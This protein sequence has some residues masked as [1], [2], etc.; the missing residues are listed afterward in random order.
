PLLAGVINIYKGERTTTCWMSEKLVQSCPRC[1][2]RPQVEVIAEDLNCFMEGIRQ[3]SRTA[4]FLAWGYSGN[5]AS[6]FRP[7]ASRLHPDIIWLG[8]FEHD[9]EKQVH[10]RRV[11][12]HE[13]SLSA[14]G[15]SKSFATVAGSLAEAGRT[16][17]AKLQIGNS[18][19]L[20]SVP[21]LPVPATVC[22]KVTAMRG[23]GVKG[24]MMSWI[25]GGY[26]S[27]QLKVAGE[28]CF[29]PTRTTDET[30]RRVAALSW[31]PDQATRV[32]DAWNRFSNA[33]QL[34]LCT[35]NAFYFGP[36]TRCPGYHLHLEKESQRAQPYNWGLTRERVRQPFE[37]Q[38]SRW[39]P[40]FT[41]AEMIDSFREMGKL[42]DEGLSL[43]KASLNGQPNL[44]ELRRQYAVAAAIRIQLDSMAN[45]IEFYTLRD[46]LREAVAADQ[47]VL[48][49]R[50][51]DVVANDIQLARE[52]LPYVRLDCTIGFESE[53][54]DYSYSP[55]LLEEKI[56]HDSQTLMTLTKWEQNGVEA[57]V[58]A[59]ILPTPPPLPRVQTSWQDW[60]RWGD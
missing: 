12:V 18:Y 31:G 45:V 5:R 25:I 59:R 56:R 38:V 40:P 44:P 35:I 49:A 47:A 36:I 24:S 15:P 14:V 2:T 41:A 37:D 19:E 30:L 3:R 58:L 43:L 9:G 22:D 27:I 23:L 29:A 1:R 13:Y 54:Y 11:E 26:P 8:N 39:V 6:D 17:Y 57:E 60:L 50:L 7:F 20:S 48:V 55:A 52:M 16:A 46:Q 53:I 28:A 51:R 34:Y 4:K 21:Y 10:G 42:W 33:F 32:A